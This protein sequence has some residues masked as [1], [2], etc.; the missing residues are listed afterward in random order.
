[1]DT[2]NKET[3]N[4][5]TEYKKIISS[6]ESQLEKAL[7]M[8]KNRIRLMN[9]YTE[10]FS[11]GKCSKQEMEEVRLNATESECIYKNLEDNLWLYRWKKVQCK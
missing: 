4:K 9:D 5:Q 10:L 3:A 2:V 7:E 6:Y 11:A 8:H 1:M